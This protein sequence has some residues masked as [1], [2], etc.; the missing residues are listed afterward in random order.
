MRLLAFRKR[1]GILKKKGYDLDVQQ[2]KNDPTI[3]SVKTEDQESIMKE[4]KEIQ[5]EALKK[6]KNAQ[7]GAVLA[8]Y[9]TEIPDAFK[10]ALNTI[11]KEVC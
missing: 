1:L 3:V 5:L 11:T 8:K 4:Q 9:V 6:S 10:N 7:K 2:F